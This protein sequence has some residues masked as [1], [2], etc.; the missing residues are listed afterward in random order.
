MSEITDFLNE[1]QVVADDS[2]L[3]IFVPS[4]ERLVKFKPLS[5]KQH[6]DILKCSIDG[7]S[8]S[9]KLGIVLNKIIIENCFEPIDFRV[10]D[11]EWILL[12]LRIASV[13]ENVVIDDKE[14]N[15][16][17]L[18]R[19]ATLFDYERS[20]T[21]KDIIVHLDVPSVKKDIE[22]SEVY[23][24]EF[25]KTSGED[26]DVSE[27]ISSMISYEII[28]FIKSISIRDQS[29]N[30]NDIN[31]A[32]KKK[33]LAS[34]PLSINHK[35]AEYIIEYRNH[36]QASFTFEDGTVLSINSDFLTRA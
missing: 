27:T 20:I 31:T 24:K 12:Q 15:L 26:A 7:V 35:I 16:R 13:G 8:G 30:F 22:V 21:V 28:K 9:V 14:Y 10:D 5:V 19:N 1:L 11:T 3:D 32:D 23:Y 18:S 33:I 4:V 6:Y 34:L 29:V 2:T 25:K 36:E 17:D